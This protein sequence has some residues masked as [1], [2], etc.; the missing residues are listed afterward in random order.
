M[1]SALSN[2]GDAA[3]TLPLAAL[4]CLWLAI[5]GGGARAAWTWLG[6]L[7]AAAALVGA[8]K[9]L[10]A[11]CGVEVRALQF[12]VVS[13]HTVL[14][15]VVWPMAFML[16][17]GGRYAPRPALVCGFALAAAIAAARVFDRAHS[18]S[19]VIA[20]LLVGALVGAC[21]LRW[22]GVPG[23]M[24]ARR[25]YAIASMLLVCLAMYGQHAPIQ[26]AIQK[27]SPYLCGG[28]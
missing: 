1:W 20:G 7:A 2:L 26:G 9:I 8:T 15:A 17:L 12:R 4:C 28:A 22:R 19:E 13:G 5:G 16:C 24:P 10:Y 14:A 27:Y 11:G 23:V 3:L 6:L 25:P 21:F 18:V